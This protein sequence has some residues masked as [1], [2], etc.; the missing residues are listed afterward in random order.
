MTNSIYLART[1]MSNSNYF[2]GQKTVKGAAKVKKSPK[3]AVFYKNK[4]LEM[5][6]FMFY[7]IF[8]T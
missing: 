7:N 2:A 3:R 5:S 6:L 8:S 4:L 1:G